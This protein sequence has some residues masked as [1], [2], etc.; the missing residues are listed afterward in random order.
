MKFS[1]KSKVQSSKSGC[2]AGSTSVS[3][4]QFGVSPNCDG[5]R[6]IG[7]CQM[8]AGDLRWPWVSGVTPETTRQRRVL[9]TA[10]GRH[11]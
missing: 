6:R 3:R 4:V 7:F 2:S 11:G 5:A 8:N 10:Y 1:S 9:P